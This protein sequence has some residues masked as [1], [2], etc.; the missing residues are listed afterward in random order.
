MLRR[1]APIGQPMVETW[2]PSALLVFGNEPTGG[3]AWN[4]AIA[5][6]A[7]YDRPLPASVIAARHAAG[8]RRPG[9]PE[10]A[11]RILA[12]D[13][14]RGPAGLQAATANEPRLERP[15]EVATNARLFLSFLQGRMI[16]AE[17]TPWDLLRNVILFVPFGA[18]LF[19]ALDPR[20]TSDG[21]AAAATFVIAALVSAGFEVLQYFV[22]FRTS[23]LFD[24]GT[25]A[26]G[27]LVG[28]IGC[29]ACLRLYRAWPIPAKDRT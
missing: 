17:S 11:G 18:L 9:T 19:A 2:D 20:M 16:H 25:N 22:G 23:S 5:Y 7:I 28:A 13:F 27:G 1:E 24:V 15:A 10:A 3:R 6:A 12:Y 8:P 29:W 26:L 4:G 14:T 21:R